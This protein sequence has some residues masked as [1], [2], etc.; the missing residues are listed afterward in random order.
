MQKTGEPMWFSGFA[1]EFSLK[2]LSELWKADQ[3]RMLV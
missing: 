2:L 1:V 3:D